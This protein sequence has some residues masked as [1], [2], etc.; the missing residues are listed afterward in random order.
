GRF[1][2]VVNRRRR[3]R[4][5]Q[6]RLAPGGTTPESFVTAFYFRLSGKHAKHPKNAITFVLGPFSVFSG[7][8]HASKV[9]SRSHTIFICFMKTKLAES[10]SDAI[11]GEVRQRYGARPRGE[12]SLA[13]AC[14][15]YT[16]SDDVGYS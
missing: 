12:S 8:D 2:R 3:R 1:T 9:A 4:V 10:S 16:R 14:C 15:T 6:S 7:R 11:R 13:E 5:A